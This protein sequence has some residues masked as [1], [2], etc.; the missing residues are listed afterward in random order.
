MFKI[1]RWLFK[2]KQK[3]LWKDVD[4]NKYQV[5]TSHIIINNY[6]II[7]FNFY[8]L[9]NNNFLIIK[10]TMLQFLLLIQLLNQK[11]QMKE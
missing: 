1:K 7:F 2:E 8:S 9:N 11:M 5:V 4:G 6:N 10:S 3:D